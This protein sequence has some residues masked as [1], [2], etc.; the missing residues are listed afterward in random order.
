MT[1]LVKIKFGSCILKSG[2]THSIASERKLKL[3][4]FM[5]WQLK[6]KTDLTASGRIIAH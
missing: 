5:R 4:V 2:I 1:S 3:V 6:K